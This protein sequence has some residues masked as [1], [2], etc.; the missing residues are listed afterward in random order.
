MA[1]FRCTDQY[2]VARSRLPLPEEREYYIRKLLPFIEVWRTEAA[3]NG[4]DKLECCR[5]FLYNLVP[6][7]VEVLIQDGIYF[8]R[9]HPEH[10]LS[11]YIKVSTT[12]LEEQYHYICPNECTIQLCIPCY[13]G[14][15]ANL[16]SGYIKVRTQDK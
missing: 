7:F 5:N 15:A 14:W 12:M 8:I 13:E 1:G 3:S 10:K 4:G 9:D 6:W 16:V 2:Y 11:N